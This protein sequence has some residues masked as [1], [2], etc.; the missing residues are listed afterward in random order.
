MSPSWQASVASRSRSSVPT[1]RS[2]GA[3]SSHEKLTSSGT[4]CPPGSRCAPVSMNPGMPVSSLTQRDS[5]SRRAF[6]H[7]EQ[8][9]T[10]LSRCSGQPA[11][12]GS[13]AVR[14]N[15]S[16]GVEGLLQCRTPHGFRSTLILSPAGP[17]ALIHHVVLVPASDQVRVGDFFPG[18]AV[19]VQVAG[20]GDE[21]VV[22]QVD[23]V[24][25]GPR[26]RP[27]PRLPGQDPCAGRPD[28]GPLRGRCAARAATPVQ[29]GCGPPTGPKPAAP[30]G[31]AAGGR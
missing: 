18:L 12:R 13:K 14:R 7:C 30:T 4:N 25:A 31:G 24:R 5:T 6:Q 26:L 21:V 2:T 1:R 20:E 23:A 8:D 3:G 16:G 15:G 10:A 9:W 17:L 11:M 19:V 28:P 27:R 22:E 29:P